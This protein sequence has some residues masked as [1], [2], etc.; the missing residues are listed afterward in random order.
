MPLS[1]RILKST[2][3]QIIIWILAS[4]S[5]IAFEANIH[6]PPLQLANTYHSE[7]QVQDYWVS[8]KLDGV[9]AYWNGHQFISKQGN[10][11]QAPE[12]FTKDFP[13]FALDGELWLDRG[14]FDA[15]SGIVRKE[16]PLDKEWQRITYQVFDLPEHQAN[17][18]E[19]LAYLKNYFLKEQAPVWLKLIPQYKVQNEQELL[20]KL[21]G[22]EALRGEG[23]MLHKGSSFYHDG[24]DDDLLKLKTYQ[25]AEAQVIGHLPGKGKYSE[26]LGALL[27]TALNHEAKGKTFKIG[28]GFSDLERQN[29]PQI[30]ATITYKYYG[31]TSKGLPR[32][33]SFMRI[34][35]G[36]KVR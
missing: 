13:P 30:G 23:L 10:I 21:K 32:F 34:R 12:W 5:A 3:L 11:Y 27:V 7:I 19:R 33:A 14:K 8:E 9:R 29:P 16:L 36:F 24:R 22:I 17:F 2:R 28:T 6:A 31:L 35:E 4:T 25:D 18:D 15:L 1:F 26:A 20:L